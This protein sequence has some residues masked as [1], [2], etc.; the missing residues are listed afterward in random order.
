MADIT[1]L[2]EPQIPRLRRY[3]RALTHDNARADDLV[4]SCLVRAIAKQHLWQEGTDLRAWLFT[5]LH[6]QY[7]NEVR[8]V[9]RELAAMPVEDL[10]A[11]LPVKERAIDA[12][13][14]RD[15]DRAM[16]RL[17]DGQ[18]Q[19]ILLVGLEGMTYEQ[20][21]QVLRVPVGTVRSRLSRGRDALR[22]LM[23]IE[24]QSDAPE[25]RTPSPGVTSI[26]QRA[27]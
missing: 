20:V 14:L 22:G 27:A 21:A 4:Q 3:A 12:L 25:S 9:A 26:T 13:Q 11:S 6:N 8:H 15:L 19:V 23:S 16:E 7:V 24:E 1:K 10:S 18:R 17:P 2:L 5:I